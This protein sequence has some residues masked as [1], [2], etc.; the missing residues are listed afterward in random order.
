[1]IVH[2]YTGITSG[3]LLPLPVTSSDCSV[4]FRSILYNTYMCR[5]LRCTGRIVADSS[6]RG[7]KLFETLS[8]GRK[9]QSV[10]TK[11][12]AIKT[13]YLIIK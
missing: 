3:M 6:H 10:R 4:S 11:F 12:H 7:H 5:T 8:S 2:F 9:L 1:M 13:V